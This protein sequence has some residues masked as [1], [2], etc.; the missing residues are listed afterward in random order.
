[1]LRF[2]DT[3]AHLADLEDLDHA[4]QRAG[5]AGVFAIVAAGT[6]LELNAKTL[7]IA[8]RF[9]GSDVRVLPTL[10]LHPWGLEE[11][12]VEP[13]ILQIRQSMEKAAGIGEIG[14]DYWLKDVK[15]LMEPL[16]LQPEDGH[17]FSTPLPHPM[18]E[19][20]FAPDA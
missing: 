12:K 11:G 15:L 6:G 8:E 9:V 20:S 17:S 1:M 18:W 14:L 2:V 3:H 4:V 16:W 5:E 13:T 10:G 7:Q 19:A